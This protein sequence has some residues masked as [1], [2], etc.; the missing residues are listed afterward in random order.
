MEIND[1]RKFNH[2]CPPQ[3]HRFALDH[4]EEDVATP[5]EPT[6]EDASAAIRSSQ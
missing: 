1:L 5:S 2:P 6:G 4:G 3:V